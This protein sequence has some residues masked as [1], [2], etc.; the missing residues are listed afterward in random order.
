MIDYCTL[1]TSAGTTRVNVKRY[2]H[3]KALDNILKY[4]DL[5]I[6]RTYIFFCICDIMSS[7]VFTCL[8]A[9]HLPHEQVTTALY[10][11]HNYM[12]IYIY[13][14]QLR[15]LYHICICGCMYIFVNDKYTVVSYSVT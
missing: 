4:T 13:L 9:L 8:F 10:I 12:Q 2:F 5:N 7:L 15:S 11:I 1:R 6:C 3:L 14:S